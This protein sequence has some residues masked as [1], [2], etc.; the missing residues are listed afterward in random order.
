MLFSKSLAYGAESTHSLRHRV[1][2]L[3][4]W[5]AHWSRSIFLRI[6]SLGLETTGS[7]QTPSLRKPGCTGT[8]LCGHSHI[9]RKH[10]LREEQPHAEPRSRRHSGLG[11]SHALPDKLSKPAR[12]ATLMLRH[13]RAQRN[14][15]YLV[16]PFR[17]DKRYSSAHG[18]FPIIPLVSLW[19]LAHTVLLSLLKQSSF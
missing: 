14:C 19:P 11:F 9:V 1:C 10:K 13:W 4:F 2:W 5:D 15:R 7:F 12:Q 18:C 6:L 3:P 8:K 17:T 16:R